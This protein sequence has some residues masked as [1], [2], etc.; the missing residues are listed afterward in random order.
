MSGE[1]KPDDDTAAPPA[2]APEDART[3]PDWAQNLSEKYDDAQESAPD[4]TPE[5]RAEIAARDDSNA[6]SD[7]PPPR[8]DEPLEPDFA[9]DGDDWSRAPE[10]SETEPQTARDDALIDAPTPETV[11]EATPPEPQD[12]APRAA[13]DQPEQ[14]ELD[15]ARPEPVRPPRS[16]PVEDDAEEQKSGGF[17]SKALAALVLLIAGAAL[18][19]WGGPKLAPMLPASLAAYLAPA[20]A[21]G[22]LAALEAQVAALNDALAA[23]VAAASARADEAAASADAALAAA[24]GVTDRLAEIDAA[25][26]ALSGG[27]GAATDPAL[28]GRLAETEAA[29]AALRAELAAA[30]AGAG[31][32]VSTGAPTA[33]LAEAR[34]GFTARADALAGRIDAQGA[35]LAALTQRV[36]ALDP[37]IAGLGDQVGALTPAVEDVGARLAALESGL[38]ETADAEK[39][40]TLALALTAVERAMMTGAPFAAALEQAAGAVDAPPPAA[41]SAA[42]ASGAPT[43]EALTA[44]FDDAA[45][46]A[47][48]AAVAAQ[49]DADGGMLSGVLARVEARITGLPVT[50]IAGDDPQAVLSRARAAVE[51]GDFAAA[52]DEIAALPAPAQAAMADWTAGARLRGEADAAL[53][54]W[55]AEVDAL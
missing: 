28:A 16:W 15:Q 11:S 45:Y 47:L 26:A 21:G 25:V 3:D 51:D 32:D 50:A 23:G 54:A 40:A 46:A 52:L 36:A 41:L 31:T 1:K 20:G 8:D 18:A 4:V 14:A 33:A 10:T 5:A 43:T 22:D 53:A 24:G 19:V 42:A 7:A 27:T 17:A 2:S 9:R 39:A 44:G 35:A 30:P 48:N 29:L 37:A 55:R 38:A 34:A 6:G 49:A 12:A 13:Y